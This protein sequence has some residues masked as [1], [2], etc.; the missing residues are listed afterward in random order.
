VF[1]SLRFIGRPVRRRSDS[2]GRDK[3]AA[4]AS[5]MGVAMVLGF[6]PAS[7]CNNRV[8]I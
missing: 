3:T 6:T 8:E 4:F 1:N 2:R 7:L 5:Q